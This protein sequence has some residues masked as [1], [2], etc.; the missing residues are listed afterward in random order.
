MCRWLVSVLSIFILTL[1]AS[2]RYQLKLTDVRNLMEEMFS[3]HVETKEM[4]A[5]LVKRSFKTF[6]E[7]FDPQKI[8]LTQSE[9][10]PFLDLSSSQLEMVID[11]YFADEYPEYQTL[12]NTIFKAIGR[13]RQWRQE[14]YTDF[15]AQGEAL[16]VKFSDSPLQN[17]SSPEQL[18]KRLRMQLMQLFMMEN[19]GKDPKFWTAERRQKVCA[20]FEKRFAHYE[21]GYLP[22]PKSEHYLAMHILRSMARGLDAHTAFL[23]LKRPMR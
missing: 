14:F 4:T 17:A 1:G 18:R 6:S 22:S 3:Y 7:Q 8:Y 23:V 5:P 11:H 10:N 20:L 19:K 15:I 13:A 9:V 12:S 2:E 16:S 21:N